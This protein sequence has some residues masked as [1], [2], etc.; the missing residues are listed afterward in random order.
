MHNFLAR[1]RVEVLC[2]GPGA[3]R[4]VSLRSGAAV[5][6]ALRTLEADVNLLDVPDTEIQLPDGV[7]VVF[8]ALHG[9]FGEDGGVQAILDQWGVS[10]TGEGVTGSRLAFDKIASKQRFARYGVPTAPYVTLQHGEPH[11]FAL[12]AV[13]KVPCQGSS[14]GIYVVKAEMEVEAALTQAFLQTGTV[15]V[16]A[17]IA[18]RELT[19]GILGNQP[20]PIIEIRPQGGFYS[21][22]N[23]YTWTNRGGAAEHE[24]PAALDRELTNRVQ[25]TAL[26]AH[27]ALGLEVYSRVDLI[28]DE[29]GQPQ[30]LEVNTIPG[31]TET[32]LLP[33]AAGVAGISM[34]KLCQRIVELSLEKRPES[35]Q[36]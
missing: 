27:R 34:P 20:L 1:K 13:V 19:V 35:V 9:T 26:A 24:C 6:K 5:A 16:E 32:S 11:R 17:F 31:M 33:E 12:P 25:E 30:V 14:V 23:K 10:Y 2:G 29:T 7:D 3:E 22:E 4:E 21:Y 8:N 36:L 18:G 15:L 28:L